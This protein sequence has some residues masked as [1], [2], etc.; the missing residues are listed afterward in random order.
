MTTAQ[1]DYARIRPL[2]VA[3]IN[4]RI[5]RGG[6]STA[7]SE[8]VT[9]PPGDLVAHDLDGIYHTGTLSWAKVSKAGAS[10]TDFA[11]RPHSALTGLTADDHTNY[12][13]ISTA[14]TVTARHTFNPPSANSPFIIGANAVD[15]MVT[16]L[17][18][19]KVG[20]Q[21][22]SVFMRKSADAPLNMNSFIITGDDADLL[23]AFG[24]AAVGDIGA[25]D[26]A[27]FSHR[28]HHSTTEY[29]LQQS[30]SGDTYLNTVTG[31]AIRLRVNNVNAA[32]VA[33]DAFT[34]Q[35]PIAL[36]AGNYASQL[37][38]WNITYA[39]AGDFRFLYT[40]ELHAKSFIADLEQALAGG[41]I[42]GKSVALLNRAFTAPAA[43]GTATL[44]VKDLPSAENMAVFQSGDIIRLRQFS[45][46]SGTLTITDCWGVVTSYADLADKEQSWTFTRSSGGN[47]GGM[48]TSTVIGKD[49]IVLDYGTTGNGFYE[50]NAIDGAYGVNSPY[51]QIVTWATHPATGQTVRVRTGNLTG[52]GFSGEYGLYAQGASTAEYIKASATAVSLRNVDLNIFNGSTR[53]VRIG[54]DGNVRFGTDA[55]TASLTTFN[56]LASTGALRVGPLGTNLPNL[57]WDG[58]TL[59]LRNN[60]TEAITLD[61]SGN[62]YFSGVMTIGTSGEIR[63]GTGTLGTNFTGLRIWRDS[64]IGRIAGYASNVLQWYAAT[65]GKLYAGAGAAQLDVDGITLQA[66]LS[67]GTYGGSVKWRQNSASTLIADITALDTAS[68][69][70]SEMYFSVVNHANSAYRFLT[71]AEKMTIM[72]SGVGI[73]APV[74]GADLH[75]VGI[76]LLEGP[77]PVMRFYESDQ[78]SAAGRWQYRIQTDIF[79]IEKNTDAAGAWATSQAALQIQEDFD[80]ILN[81]TSGNTGIGDTTPDGKLDVAQASTTAAIPVLELQ[82]ADLSEEFVNF[83][84]TIGTGNPIEAVGAKVLT[85][86]HFVRMQIDGVGY[87]YMPVGTIA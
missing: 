64:T 46:A 42:I 14:R 54:S 38:G 63:Q 56:F 23:F 34:V 53:T 36:Q 3:D 32:T 21:L 67:L 82:Q 66:P 87:R 11:T 72:Q 86:T 60:T 48:A 45:R 6:R 17:N 31:G 22:E 26:S 7:P 9:G 58:S 19:Q 39:G 84:A 24:R 79:R 57:Y 85:T 1:Q 15:Q 10:L 2:V 61:S 52:V 59:A 13:H 30:A 18:A 83:I 47:A 69:V 81:P 28:D 37:T 33:A 50:V 68:H 41:Q 5:G 25:V 73:N 8:V 78:T 29:A 40:D 77:S 65:D 20:G 70:S 44:Y 27:G 74:P 12:V 75:V 35:S 16:G 76:A 49:A 43:G 4:R 51:S 62:A 80:I 71:S 55:D